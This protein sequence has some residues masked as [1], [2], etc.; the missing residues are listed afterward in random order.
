VNLLFG[1]FGIT[2]RLEGASIEILFGR[3]GITRPL[4]SPTG[5]LL[6]GKL[7][8]AKQVFVTDQDLGGWYYICQ[9][10]WGMDPQVKEF[11][12]TLTIF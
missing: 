5:K 4:E 11:G 10:I 1:K 2:T 12:I 3:L 9:S 7:G 6:F 8:H